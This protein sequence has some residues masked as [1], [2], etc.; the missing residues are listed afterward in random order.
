[1][2]RR[3]LI[4]LSIKERTLILN[5]ILRLYTVGDSLDL[6]QEMITSLFQ[7]TIIYHNTHCSDEILIYIGRKQTRELDQMVQLVL[8]L[9]ANLNYKIELYYQYHFAILGLEMTSS[10]DEIALY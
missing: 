2:T 8:K 10:I 6:L 3:Y 5:G 9:F 1:M 7:N 4:L